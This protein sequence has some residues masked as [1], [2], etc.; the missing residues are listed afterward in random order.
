MTETGL[1]EVSHFISVMDVQS[2]HSINLREIKDELSKAIIKT[3][4]LLD[5]PVPFQQNT[6][7]LHSSKIDKELL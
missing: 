2:F 4:T 6:L 3:Q 1:T 5:N 7:N